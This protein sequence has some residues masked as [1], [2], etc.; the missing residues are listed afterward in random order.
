M[1]LHSNHETLSTWHSTKKWCSLVSKN[2]YNSKGF[3]CMWESG[4]MVIL[5]TVQVMEMMAMMVMMVVMMEVVTRVGLKNVGSS[6]TSI[7]QCFKER[8]NEE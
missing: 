8:G 5:I 7:R 6:M 2:I 4:M 1:G 3:K